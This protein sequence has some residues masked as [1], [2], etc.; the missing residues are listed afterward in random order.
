MLRAPAC[1][2]VVAVASLSLFGQIILQPPSGP[3]SG[4][5]V[6]IA[7]PS[8][9]TSG[10]ILDIYCDSA[11]TNKC[12][13]FGLGGNFAF[14]GNSAAF[15]AQGQ[16]GASHVDLWGG[17][18]GAA[19][20]HQYSASLS[21]PAFGGGSLSTSSSGGHIANGTYYFVITFV[22]N[23]TSG[24]GGETT[25]SSEGMVVTT[26]TGVSTITITAPTSSVA[27]GSEN[28]YG[29]QI[30]ESTMSGMEKLIVPPS[31]VCTLASQTYGGNS[32]CKLGSNATFSLANA[33][34]SP[35]AG[36][37]TM[38]TTAGAY[39]GY[40]SMSTAT[41]GVP[42]FG[43]AVPGADCGTGNVL[44]K[45]PM[46]NAGDM[47]YGGTNDPFNNDAPPTQLA[48]N[49]GAKAF[50][51]EASSTPS[52]SAITGSDLPSPTSSTLGGVQSVAPVA[53]KWINSISTAGV[54]S[55]AEPGFGDLPGTLTTTAQLPNGGGGVL[56]YCN[57]TA[58]AS[59]TLALAPAAIT[60][61]CNGT[62]SN[63]VEVPV[64]SSGTIKSLSVK[65]GTGGVNSSSGAFTLTKNGVGQSVACTTGTA[66]T[67][68]DT[69]HSFTV[70]AT[71]SVLVKFTTQASET[72]THCRATFEKY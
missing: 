66:T 12:F 37:P 29:Y 35:G 54:P 47:I 36:Y 19:F 44:V 15:G 25:A 50:L 46:V 16:S 60:T 32:V 1:C 30:Y 67:C 33:F 2:L 21:S 4:T 14:T 40:W 68:S 9:W 57:G 62:A 5:V 53:S 43:A 58:A 48:A 71:D 10:D 6:S 34:S 17:T 64:A 70:V 20:L 13:S 39:S 56:F 52:W 18:P 61:G 3:A 72:L 45:N 41:S 42:C 65:C 49:S 26:G 69:T 51:T 63:A 8:S 28:A 27:S 22:N 23:Q 38:N 31:T 24:S 11:L 55:L 59:S 7:P